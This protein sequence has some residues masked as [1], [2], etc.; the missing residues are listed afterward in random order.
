VSQLLHHTGLCD[1]GVI[2]GSRGHSAGGS[3]FGKSRTVRGL[4]VGRLLLVSRGG[5][6]L[7]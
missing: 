6:A 7:S 5:L 4:T 3:G 1:S 2:S